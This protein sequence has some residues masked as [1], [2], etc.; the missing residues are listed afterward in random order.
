MGRIKCF[1][2]WQS[3]L[4][5][6]SGPTSSSI[7]CY[8]GTVSWRLFVVV[9]VASIA[10]ACGQ[11]EA[12]PTQ[13]ATPTPPPTFTL[14]P[15]PTL[16]IKGAIE[17]D[18][19]SAMMVSALNFL[20]DPE[21]VDISLIEKMGASGNTSFIP[22]LVDLL[23][24]QGSMPQETIDPIIKVLA[25]LTGEDFGQFGWPDWFEWLGKHPEVKAPSGYAS[26]KGQIL[27][28]IDPNF[29]L[30]FYDGVKARIRLEEIAWGGVRKDGIPDLIDPP[31]VAPDQATYLNPNDRIFGVSINGEHRAYPL[32]I[33]NPH[34]MAND[35]VGGEPIALAY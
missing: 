16:I 14:T 19:P 15:R 27:S 32:R 13:T 17:A 33:M 25:K 4:Y 26:W 11:P 8:M 23:F 28:L 6:W 24:F 2:E 35:I 22:V 31:V 18:D 34:E 20:L 5:C 30:F 9:L 10:I 21:A 29:S 1:S 12:I 3:V 7:I